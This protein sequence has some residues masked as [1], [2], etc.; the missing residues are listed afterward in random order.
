MCTFCKN[1]KETIIHVLYECDKIKE[2][3]EKTKRICNHFFEVKI[4]INA[5]LAILNNYKGKSP[6]CTFC[7]NKKET[8]IHVLYECDK[9]KELWEKTKSICN[10][11]FEVKI[12][13]NAEL[14]ILNNYKGKK[15]GIINILIAIMK[16]HIYAKKCYEEIPNFQEF[17]YKLAEWYEVEKVFAWKNNKYELCIKKW[18]NLF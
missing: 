5:E 13:I 1:K 16:Q 12:E 6:L 15:K 14:A 2:L 11:F 8:I 10:H 4:E 9:I 3:W 7:K 18:E 17:M